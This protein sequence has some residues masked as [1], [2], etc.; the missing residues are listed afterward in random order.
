M[1]GVD[2]ERKGLDDS[3]FD[4]AETQT[5]VGSYKVLVTSPNVSPTGKLPPTAFFTAEEAVEVS[6]VSKERVSSIS[7][8]D[9]GSSLRE[10]GKASEADW[11]SDESELDSEVEEERRRFLEKKRDNDVH[12]LAGALFKRAF[13]LN[14]QNLIGF[15]RYAHFCLSFTERTKTPL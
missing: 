3:L 13:Q 15:L 12:E 11:Q 8:E 14:D 6:A 5:N 1:A 9:A 7:A 10:S 2:E 4:R